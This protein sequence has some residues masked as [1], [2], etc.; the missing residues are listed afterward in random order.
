MYIIIDLEATCWG[1]S[2]KKDNEIIE[3]GAV[4]IDSNYNKTGE[5]QTF[6]KPVRNPILS[7]FCKELTSISQEEIDNA[8]KFPLVLKNFINWIEKTAG[9]DIKNII[10]CSWG[11]YDDKQL[12]RDCALHNVKY[13]FSKHRSLKHE[14]AKRRKIKTVGMKKALQ[15]CSIELKGT[16]HRALSDTLNITNIFIKEKMA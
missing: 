14:F 11:Y 5:Y 2:I 1:N 7:E 12:K 10:F 4:L 15:I 9:S 16:H 13:P 6:I 8:Q 3:I